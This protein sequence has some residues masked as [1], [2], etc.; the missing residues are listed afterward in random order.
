MIIESLFSL[1]EIFLSQRI[2]GEHFTL[3]IMAH[4]R[5]KR[6]MLQIV[7]EAGVYVGVYVENSTWEEGNIYIFN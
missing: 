5:K 6:A 7:D 2:S 4:C 1:L 3:I